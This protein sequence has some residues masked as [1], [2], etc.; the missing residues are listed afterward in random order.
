M[1]RKE[2]LLTLLFIVVVSIIFS[3]FTMQKKNY[4]CEYCGHK[5][6]DVRQLTSASCS[7]HPD[8]ANKGKHKLYEGSEKSKYTCKYCG[9]QFPS[10]MVMTVGTCV[11]HPKGSNKGNHSPAL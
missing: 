5:F 2:F 6:P 1:K 11:N 10:I 8:G 3:A 4:Y 7:R 9:K